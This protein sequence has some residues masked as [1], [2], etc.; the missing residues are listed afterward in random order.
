[1]IIEIIQQN[2]DKVIL[3]LFVVSWCWLSVMLAIAVDLYSGIKKA[4]EANIYISSEGY[5][6]T[7]KK[8]RY[9][10]S[11]M[12]FALL[13]DSFD[14][15]TPYLLPYPYGIIPFV[16]IL[17]AIALIATEWKSVREKADEKARRNIDKTGMQMFELAL[18]NKDFLQYF[19][20]KLEEEKLKDKEN[21]KPLE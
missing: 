8:A 15:I 12:F 20:T 13:F 19:Y 10:F 14:V 6:R 3:I 2:W 17:S 16:S 9:Y 21:E 7:V 5:K 1:M 11:L 18:K 4:K